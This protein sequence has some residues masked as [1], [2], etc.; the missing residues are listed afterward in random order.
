MEPPLCTN[1]S[2]GYLMQL[3]VK[4]SVIFRSL[5]HRNIERSKPARYEIIKLSMKTL[6]VVGWSQWTK[7]RWMKRPGLFGLYTK[8]RNTK[9][10]KCMSCKNYTS[11]ACTQAHNIYIWHVWLYHCTKLV[12]HGLLQTKQCCFIQGVFICKNMIIY[13]MDWSS[14]QERWGYYTIPFNLG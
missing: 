3:S 7:C 11:K 12:L 14:P 8:L 1:G 4:V 5:K 2:A 6:S 13:T 9:L 10:L